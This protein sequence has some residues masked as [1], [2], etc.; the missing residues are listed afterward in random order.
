MCEYPWIKGDIVRV[1]IEWIK[2]AGFGCVTYPM[3]LPLHI[4]METIYAAFRVLAAMGPVVYTVWALKVIQHWP[5][6]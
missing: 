1:A 3:A 6:M 2:V 4:I 5:T